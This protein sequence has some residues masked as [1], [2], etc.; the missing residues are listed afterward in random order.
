MRAVTVHEFGNLDKAGVEEREDPRPGDGEVLVEVRAAPVNY[1]DLVTFRGEYQFKPALPYV[2]GKGPS[3]VVRA[4]G[5]G[6]AGLA[7][8][9]RVLA[10]AEYGGYAELVAVD[11]RQAYRLPDALSFV[12]AA[13][14]SL[15]FDTAWMAL[16]DR[17][18]IR[19]GETVLVLGATG[20]VGL[21]AVQLARAMGARLVLAGVSRPE[22]FS[23]AAAAGA[24]AMVDLSRPDLRNSVREQVLA[25]TGGEGVDIVIDPLGG[26]PFDGAVRSLAWRGRLVVIGFAAG[27]IPVLKANYPL[28]KNIE[29]SG[30]QISDYRKRLPELVAE[31]YR[32]VFAF[33]QQ[34]LVTAPPSTTVALAEWKTAFR[35]VDAGGAT[36]R[37]VLVPGA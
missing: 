7:P 25:A 5:A 34:G 22:R 9:D 11:H 27:R 15:G 2:P 29:V 12:D 8:G 13:S 30:L 6:V 26:D 28:L 36:R 35:T 16:R 3:G 23:A 24:D 1:V 19:P 17:A 31:C 20:A 33:H 32:E 14:M 21:A 18:R 4:V 37:Q 10:M